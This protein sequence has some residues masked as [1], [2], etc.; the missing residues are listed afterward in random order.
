MLPPK[1]QTLSS[2]AGRD[3]LP[4]HVST[5]PQGTSS[6][7]QAQTRAQHQKVMHID[8][9]TGEDLEVTIEG[10]YL[11]FKG[12]MNIHLLFMVGWIWRFHS[13]ERT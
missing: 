8:L 12:L 2:S 3:V 6:S 1:F 13:K 10:I 5:T 4:V 7:Y 11:H 9:F